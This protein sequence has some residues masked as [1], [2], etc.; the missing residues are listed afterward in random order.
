[1]ASRT[2][3]RLAAQTLD[4]SIAAPLVVA[5]RVGRMARAGSQT[6]RP[7]S[8][9]DQREFALMGL[10]K[11]AAFWESW[12]AMTMQW[13]QAAW[14]LWSGAAWGRLPGN[15]MLAD[16]GLRILARG[17]SPVHRRA[18]GNAKRLSHSRRR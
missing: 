12:L 6:A 16:Q 5:H 4:L 13:Q 15:A 10:E 1:M 18:V 3:R 2:R 14:R 11:V 7:L 8:A 17:L 9:R